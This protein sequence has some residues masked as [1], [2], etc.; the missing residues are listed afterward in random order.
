VVAGR[1]DD[2]L[3][4]GDDV[5]ETVLVVDPPGP[6][7]RQVVLERFGLADAGKRSVGG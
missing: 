5:D 7:P 3:R 1:E 2:D 6:R 4:L